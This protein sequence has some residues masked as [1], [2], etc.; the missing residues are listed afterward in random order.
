QARQS[1]ESAMI[2]YRVGK[3]DFLTLLDSRMAL[4]NYE[5]EYYD[6]VADLRMKVAELESVI[7]M[8]LK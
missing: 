6:S 5:K 1:L 2:A 7:G 4:Y 8:D 3:V